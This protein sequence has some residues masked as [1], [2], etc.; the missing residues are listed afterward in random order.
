MPRSAFGNKL[1]TKSYR[2]NPIIARM[3]RWPLIGKFIDN[4]LFRGDDILFLTR[5]KLIPVNQ[6]VALPGQMCLPSQVVEHFINQTDYHWIM[7]ECIC[8]EGLQCKDY[9]R[10]LG[11][12]F[13]G[14]AAVK[15]NPALG[16]RVSK[17]EAI[18]HARKCREAG[19]VHMI[20]R[21]KLDAVWL[22]VGP[23]GKLLTVC[24]C[25][26]CC[27]I[28]KNLPLLSP[29]IA[30]KVTRLPGVK[31][32]VNDQCTGCGACAEKV[33]FAGAIRMYDQLAVINETLCKGCGRCVD[34]CDQGAINI[35]F[36]NERFLQDTI[37]RIHQAVDL[38]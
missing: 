38:S 33:C 19:L 2:W 20:G 15:I 9:P 12:L 16:R 28:W 6:S 32:F 29:E 34:A 18:A 14:E 22:D 1:L 23:G 5:D 37:S 35:S 8:R 25:C 4:W 26:P 24:N 17:E 13:L 30:N 36:N 31:V 10:D 27:C 3:T 11:C 7:N 21:N